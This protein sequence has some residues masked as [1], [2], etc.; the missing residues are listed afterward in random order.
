[1][2]RY[3]LNNEQ[4]DGN[5]VRLTGDDAHHLTRV[6]RQ[7]A[8]DTIIVCNENQQCF[9]LELTTLDKDE[10]CGI[11]TSEITDKAELPVAVTIA[12]GLVKGDKFEWVIQKGTECG[13]AGFMPVVM[14]RSVVKLD[15]KKEKKK[16]E[17]W[18]KIAKEAAE[19]S[20]RAMLPTVYD[21]CSFKSFVS[22][23]NEYDVCLFAYEETAKQ[24][25]LS[26]LRQTLE[27][28]KPNAKV[29]LLV[30]PEGGISDKEAVAL[31]A[32]GF[33]ACALGP[34][35]LRTETAPLYFLGAVSYALE[36]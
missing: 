6:M 11:I 14:D 21:V 7:K 36:C 27:T 26:R 19:Q 30:G 3:F 22:L 18:Q 9:Y 1:M 32:A 8:G 17:R 33:T 15:P 24:H 13:A 4:F 16:I 35:I 20:H 2:Q 31:E 25:E 29:L 23:V 28:I 5:T 10:V 34:R 12:Q